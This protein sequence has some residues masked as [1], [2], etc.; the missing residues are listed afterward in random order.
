MVGPNVTELI[1]EISVAMKLE[2][3]IEEIVSSIHP[4]PTLS[5]AIHEASHGALGHY[6]SI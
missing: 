6:L 5:E 1:S 4:H 2:G 3:T